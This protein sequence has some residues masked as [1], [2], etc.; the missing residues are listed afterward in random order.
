MHS[1][2]MMASAHALVLTE[3]EIN[4][5]G[6]CYVRLRGRKS[7]LVAWFLTLVGID[8]TTE[9]CVYEDHIEISEG[10][11][12]GKINELVP[13]SSVSNLGTGLVKPFVL[14]GLAA[15]FIISALCSLGGALFTHGGAG[16]WAGF[17]FSLIL[18]VLSIV[19]YKIGR[20]MMAYV[21]T[22]GGTTSGIF[23]KRSIIESKTLS[24]EEVDQIIAILTK[25]VREKHQ[26]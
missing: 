25:L 8:V 15:L 13:I 17:L 19:A 7:G 4:E 23:V 16:A 9:F 10:S 24:E 20:T 11:V 2:A 5:N 12:S 1:F 21:V 18:A 3:K 6:P 22:D 26:A 14:L